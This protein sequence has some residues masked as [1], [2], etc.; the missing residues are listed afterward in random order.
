MS[1][2][3][4]NDFP[5]PLRQDDAHPAALRTESTL[6]DVLER[7]RH[8]PLP[9]RLYLTSAAA[10]SGRTARNSVR[11][12]NNCTDEA[13]DEP[14]FRHVRAYFRAA[15]TTHDFLAAKVAL[16]H[17]VSSYVTL[18]PSDYYGTACALASALSLRGR[19]TFFAL[20]PQQTGA[21][22]ADEVR[23]TRLVL[24]MDVVFTK[25]STGHF[26]VGGN[27]ANIFRLVHCLTK[28]KKDK[29]P[30]A[31]VAFSFTLQLCLTTYVI[32]NNIMELSNEH[33][34]GMDTIK[35][36]PIAVL[37]SWYNILLIIPEIRDGVD[38]F[39]FWGKVGV[40]QQLDL[41]VNVAIPIILLFSGFILILTSGDF[42]DAVLNTAALIFIIK[43]DDDLPSLLG[44]DVA[45]SVHDHLIDEALLEFDRRSHF[46]DDQVMKMA[47]LC[48]TRIPNIHFQDIY[49]MKSSESR[50]AYGDDVLVMPHE[51]TTETRVGGGHQVAKK[52][53]VTADCLFKRI[54][55]WY[56]CCDEDNFEDLATAISVLKLVK[57]DNSVVM[58]TCESEHNIGTNS[59]EGKTTEEDG[60]ETPYF[61]SVEGVYMITQ[62]Q[63]L[64]TIVNL[65]ICG[66][67]T[68]EDFLEAFSYYSLWPIHNS[69]FDAFSTN[70]VCSRNDKKRVSSS[71]SETDITL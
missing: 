13:D 2:V 42:I 45:H 31:L 27:R 62:L 24:L 28:G 35:F 20:H 51:V 56:A 22:T 68:K 53:Q 34:K 39:K 57:I 40:L 12:S 66:S 63:I 41:I 15:V 9:T 25:I 30:F 19:N 36:I 44:L 49:V 67:E 50:S 38:C 8:R 60:M 18:S 58:I 5:P 29:K 1:A 64:G 14:T 65:R 11:W 52:N 61:C 59:S 47:E 10:S 69:V 43:I 48:D 23:R 54:E 37:A 71:H 33:F 21:G 17:L 70:N 32:V 16:T 46:S 55:W 6:R 4:D 7:K 26:L 3:S